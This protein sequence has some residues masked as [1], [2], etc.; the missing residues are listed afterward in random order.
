MFVVRFVGR[1]RIN[2]DRIIVNDFEDYGDVSAGASFTKHDWPT[3]GMAGGDV[4]GPE[5]HF[6][7]LVDRNAMLGDVLDVT[8]RFVVEVPDD[9]D[10]SYLSAP[11]HVLYHLVSIGQGNPLGFRTLHSPNR[12]SSCP[13]LV[14]RRM[15]P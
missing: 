6:F 15:P 7:N 11:L 8:F 1:D 2:R 3:G 13:P 14:A 12:A 4:I 9:V 10:D 5:E